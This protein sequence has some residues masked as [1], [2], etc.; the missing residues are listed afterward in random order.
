MFE[1]T[2]SNSDTSAHEDELYEKDKQK[3]LLYNKKITCPVCDTKFNARAIKKSSYRILKKDSDFF[4]RYSIINPYFYD[5]WVC[6]TCGYAAIKTDFEHLDDFDANT[7]RN[8]IS[9]KWHSKCYPEV[10]DINLAIQRY[11]LSLLNYHV[12][13]AKS[14]KK[15]INLL[16]IAWMYRL[17]EDK[18]SELE[19]LKHALENFNDAYSSEHFPICGMN[20]FTT[21]YL[22]GEL[23]RRTGKEDDALLWFGQVITSPLA[24]QKIKNIARDQKDLIKSKIEDTKP[25]DNLKN[26]KKQSIFSKFHK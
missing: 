3:L 11:K 16:K 18:K 15:A 5:V 1:K 9:P 10:Y 12:I 17:K 20:R 6:D 24:P 14:S 21:M 7:V 26:N 22:I 23:Y 2:S 8:E 13:N 25:E 19:Y 4:I